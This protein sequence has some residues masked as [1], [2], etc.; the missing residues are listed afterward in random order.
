MSSDELQPT[1][2]DKETL[3]KLTH[4]W[5]RFLFFY[6]VECVCVGFKLNPVMAQFVPI[7][8]LLPPSSGHRATFGTVTGSLITINRSLVKKNKIK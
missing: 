6:G 7:F 5:L 1:R 2:P 8:R 3:S 4:T